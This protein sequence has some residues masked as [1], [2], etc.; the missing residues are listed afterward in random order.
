MIR[1]SPR[2]V[3]NF[4]IVRNDVLRDRRLSYRARGVLVSLLSRPDNWRM[5]AEQLANETDD[6]GRDAVRKALTELENV[7]YLKRIRIRKKDGTFDHEAVVFD[8]TDEPAPENPPTVNQ[9]TVSQATKE[10]LI[11]TTEKENKTTVVDSDVQD[12]FSAWLEVTGR[13]VNKTKLDSKRASRIVWALKNYPKQDVIDAV[14]GWR[15]SKFH[16]GTNERGKVYND[17]TL[18]LRD[19][20][21]LEEFRELERNGH[22]GVKAWKKLRQLLEKEL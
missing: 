7:G 16:S 17:L 22:D 4:T 3:N 12:V 15:N 8:T 13:D 21:H 14:T 19:A 9:P 10:Q 6:E 11:R 18:L 20:Q 1:R 2:P 5:S